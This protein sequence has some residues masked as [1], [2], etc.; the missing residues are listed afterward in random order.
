MTI[1]VNVARSVL[2]WA[3]ERSDRDPE[4]L[5]A[6]FPG[7]VSWEA[8]TAQP[9]LKQ[10]ESFAAA[11]HVPIGYLMLQA[12]PEETLPI[13]DLRTI[14]DAPLG[15]PSPNLLDTIFQCQTR[16]DWYRGYALTQRLDPLPFVGSLT[17][18]VNSTVAAARLRDALDFS[19][20][21]RGRF[22]TWS[23]AL[24]G[25]AEELEAAGV[26][27]MISGVVGSNPHRGLDPSEF[28]GFTLTDDL[29]PLI[30][31]NGADTK[32][33]QLFTL[34][35]EAAHVWL[36]R[37]GV[38]NASLDH[39]ASGQVERWCNQVAAE[40]LVPLDDLMQAFRPTA[41]L[42]EELDRLARRY[43]ASTLVVLR[44]VQDA[45]HL[46]WDHFRSAYIAELARIAGFQRTGDGGDF[47]RTLPVRASKRFVRA[48][49]GATIGGQTLYRD[50]FRMLG[51]KKQ[52]TFDELG[53]RLGF[54]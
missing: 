15:R 39:P 48:L 1:R 42:T 43:K 51:I 11:A 33:A 47:Y 36:G 38:S 10:L 40:L 13:P 16:Q 46:T 45:G 50:A 32:A 53:R 54:V 5:A 26:L 34:G 22:T 6:R 2:G 23:A 28:R 25:L 37:S 29:A 17:T 49:V 21:A 27:V 30:F 44:R 31:V 14:G 18:R 3:W 41:D 8:G 9:T 35:H 12:P 52:A 20:Q 24:S 19:M 4:E 7:F